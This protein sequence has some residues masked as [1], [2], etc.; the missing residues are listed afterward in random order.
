[1]SITRI[2]ALLLVSYLLLGCERSNGSFV[3][4]FGVPGGDAYAIADTVAKHIKENYAFADRT[5]ADRTH[6]GKIYYVA[7]RCVP[8][9]TFYEIVEPNDIHVIEELVRQSLPFAGIDR[10]SLI[11]YEKQNWVT[12]SPNGGGYRGHENTV[13]HI[14]IE[15]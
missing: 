13:K 14:T 4:H 15:K 5:T 10:V 1:L 7:P 11:F 2:S 12:A 6:S 9:F 8:S 3:C